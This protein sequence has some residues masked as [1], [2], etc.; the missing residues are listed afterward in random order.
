MGPKKSQDLS[1]QLAN[2]KDVIL[3][4][5]DAID[6]KFNKIFESIQETKLMAIEAINTASEALQTSNENLTTMKKDNEELVK[7]INILESRIDDQANRS[8]RSTLVFRGIP[9]NEK[10]WDE[11]SKKLA[12]TIAVID[13]SVTAD[14][15]MNWIE[16]AHRAPQSRNN[17]NNKKNAN[18]NIIA[19][20]NSWKESER[21]KRMIIEHNRRQEIKTIF[22]EQLQTPQLME[23]TNEA[24]LYWKDLKEKNPAWKLFISHPA[25]LMGK[26]PNESSYKVVKEF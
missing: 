7:K 4:R 17:P 6:F 11:T 26:K 20:F 9:G 21:V 25:K 24:K 2:F 23:G 5:L 13:K 18:N 10:S 8:M 14:Q 16:R 22:V 19:K 15:A 1:E 3:K 12:S